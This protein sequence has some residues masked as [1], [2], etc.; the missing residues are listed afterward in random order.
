M[1]NREPTKTH[2][3]EKETV[4]DII[5]SYMI[6]MIKVISCLKPGVIA[7]NKSTESVWLEN[8]D[9]LSKDTT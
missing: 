9:Q 7:E 1:I 2:K 8:L 5:T 6:R 3:T 4:Q